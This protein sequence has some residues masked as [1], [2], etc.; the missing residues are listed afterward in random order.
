M[1]LLL[2]YKLDES[3]TPSRVA[4]R[5]GTT[6]ND[7]RELQTLELEEPVGW[8]AL[9]LRPPNTTCASGCSIASIAAAHSLV[10]CSQRPRGR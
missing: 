5:A 10:L 6:L 4:V 7:L 9:E 2:D 8:V 3:Y 1:A